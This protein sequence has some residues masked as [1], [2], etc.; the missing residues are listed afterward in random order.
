MI[1]LFCSIFFI[2]SIG[3][4]SFIGSDIRSSCRR[5]DLVLLRVATNVVGTEK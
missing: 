2:P 1:A 3:H 5:I 4:L